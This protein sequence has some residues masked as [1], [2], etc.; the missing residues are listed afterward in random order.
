MRSALSFLT[1]AGRARTP[2]DR[3][4]IW[5]PVVG[6]LIGLAVGGIW[7]GTMH[8]WPPVVAAAIVLA[9]DA[10]LTGGLHW[11]GLADCGD[12]LLPPLDR[13]RRLDVMSDPRVGAFGVLAIAALGLLRFAVLAAGPAKVWIVAALW[14]ASRTVAA[15][16]TL[17]GRYARPGGLATGFQVEPAARVTPAALVAVL[18]IVISVVLALLDR[19]GHG[20]AA[21]GAEL[22]TMVAVTCLAYRRL[23]GYTGDVLGAQIVLGETAGLLLWAARW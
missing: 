23:G 6:A 19:P 10:V 20:V 3:T 2:S 11:D 1:I 14:C 7:V 17:L 8:A 4:L 13:Q 9:A 5:F 16:V 21:L 12:G 15:L 18:G 22:L